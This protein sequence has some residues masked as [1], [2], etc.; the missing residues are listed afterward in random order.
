MMHYLRGCVSL[1]ELAGSE[2]GVGFALVVGGQVILVIGIV[3]DPLSGNVVHS[4]LR[5][6]DLPVKTFAVWLY[7]LDVENADQSALDLS[8]AEAVVEPA[9][10][11]VEFK[12]EF[13]IEDNPDEFLRDFVVDE[14]S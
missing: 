6:A 12:L 3:V 14:E 1:C 9:T 5:R 4:L 7:R 13:R 11:A 10:R 8:T 2:H